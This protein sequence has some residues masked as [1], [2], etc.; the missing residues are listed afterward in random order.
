MNKLELPYMAIYV[1]DYIRDTRHLTTEQ[2]GAYFLLL[3]EYWAKGGCLPD[4]DEQLARI[5]G[6]SPAKWRKI[7][8]LIKAFFYDGWR[9]EVL[10]EQFAKSWAR[11]A[12]AA[13]KAL[14]P[15]GGKT[16]VKFP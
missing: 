4:D 6:L 15:N 13:R 10:D 7:R 2:H 9:H 16:V 3:A 11:S 8:P 14:R 1:G 12:N 5:V